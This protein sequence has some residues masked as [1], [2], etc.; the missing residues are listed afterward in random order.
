MYGVLLIPYGEE[1]WGTRYPKSRSG[2]LGIQ[3]GWTLL[4][5]GGEQGLGWVV[6]IC[7]L[8]FY[9]YTIL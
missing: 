3:R 4:R 9:M 5:D 6:V 8:D 2:R 1:R 7:V